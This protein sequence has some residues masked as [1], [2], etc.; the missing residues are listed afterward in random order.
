MLL[1]STSGVT[2][3]STV[4]LAYMALFK[5]HPESD[6]IGKMCQWL[7]N[8]VE[9][10]QP[11]LHLVEKVIK[12]HRDFQQRQVP[13]TDVQAQKRRELERKTKEDELKEIKERLER[14]EQERLRLEREAEIREMKHR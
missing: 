3:T 1:H 4:L 6:N 5:A 9:L 8:S 12:T 11:N 7:R 13:L 2:R 10:A 14:E